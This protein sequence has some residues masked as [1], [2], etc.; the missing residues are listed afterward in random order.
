MK[1][2]IITISL[3]LCLV[4]VSNYTVKCFP[5]QNHNDTH[6]HHHVHNGSSHSH[7]HNHSK[8]NISVVDFL[9]ITEN[10]NNFVL[11]ISKQSY[12]DTLTF[13]PTPIIKSLFRPPIS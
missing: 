2:N 6:L 9:I 8:I 11:N 1:L 12:F 4:F 10:K 7:S 5:K 3:A 13:I